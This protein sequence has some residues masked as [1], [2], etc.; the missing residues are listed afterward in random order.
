VIPGYD[1]QPLSPDADFFGFFPNNFLWLGGL[2][3]STKR[4]I[5]QFDNTGEHDIT[6]WMYEDGFRFDKFFVT[7]DPNRIPE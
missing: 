2:H 4:A 5:L 7:A 6:F 1:G 3:N